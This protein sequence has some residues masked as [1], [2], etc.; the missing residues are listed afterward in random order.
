MINLTVDAHDLTKVEGTP[1]QLIVTM[2][3]QEMG[4]Q[5]LPIQFTIHGVTYTR[6]SNYQGE[7]R[8]NINLGVG[9]YPC[10]ISFDGDSEY[11]SFTRQVTVTVTGK[12]G[13]MIVCNDFVKTYGTPEPLKALLYYNTPVPGKTLIFTINGVSYERVT[14]SEGYA[15]L[16]INL[17]PG[18]YPCTVHFAGDDYYSAVTI[19]L[20]VTVRSDTR[21]EGTNI[22]KKA[23]QTVVYQCAVYDAFNNRVDCDVSL[24]V[25]GVTYIRHTDNSGLA[26]LNIRLSEGDYTLT[27]HYNGDE[28]HNGSSIVNTVHVDPDIQSITTVKQGMV[29]VPGPNRGFMESHIYLSKSTVET[30]ANYSII[31]NDFS[32]S[33]EAK[34]D[35]Y[36]TN[37]EITETDPRVKTAKFTTPRYIDLTTGRYYATITCPYH[38]NF[39]GQIIDIDYDKKTGLYTYQCQDGRRAYLTKRRTSS[40]Y[41][42]SAT[43]YD[44]LESLL[45]VPSFYNR[46]GIPAPLPKD[47]RENAKLLLT[48]LRPLEAYNLK[49]S[50]ISIKRNAYAEPCP[51]MLSYD[52]TIDKIMNL[53]HYGS[54]PVDVYFD[55]QGICQIEPIDLDKWL[56]QGI[57]L[58]HSDLESYKY[59][60]NI[61]NVITGV[62]VKAKNADEFSDANYRYDEWNDLRFYFGTNF[63]M[64]DPVTT[65]VQTGGDS[66]NN[67]NSTSANSSASGIMSGS[68]TFA[69][70]SDNITGYS[71]DMARIN[72]VISALQAKGHKAYSLGVGSNANQSHG[73]KSNSK[74]VINIFIVG[75]VCAGTIK[76]FVDGM[77]RGYYH[78]DHAIF[79]FA[80]C[81]TDNWIS[82]NALANKK[83]IRAW[84]DNFSSGIDTSIT[85]KQFFEKHPD[86][87]HYVAGQPNESWDS[88]VE[89]L[90]NGNLNCNGGN[91]NTSATTNNNTASDASNNTTTVVDETAT[92][93]KALEAMSNS[94]RDLLSFEIKLPLNHPIFKQ[95]HTNQMLWTELPGDFQ[96]E[97]LEKIFNIFGEATYK[98]NRGVKY[99]ENRWYVEKMN[100]K[101]DSNGLFATLTLNPFPSSYS[102]YSNA[103]KQYEEAYNQAFKATTTE[104]NTN[105][106][107]TNTS[108]TLVK[109][110]GNT[111]LDE[112]IK[113]WVN[114]K[115][116]G[117]DK[118]IAIHNG[119][120]DYGVKYQK[121]YDFLKSGGSITKAFQNAHAGLNCGDTSVLTVG[122][123]Q[124]VGLDAYV[125]FRCDHA[126]FFTVIVIGGTK[127]YSDLVWSEGAYSRRPWN[128]T[129]Q[130]NKCHSKYTAVNIH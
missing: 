28:T 66:T 116:T 130:N 99:R 90:V 119:L 113:G 114:G 120:K 60:F 121:Y 129:W 49:F 65:T 98:V 15:K 108:S 64:I 77:T 79:M 38:E 13:T 83:Q 40:T 2:H 5:N 101:C 124:A 107:T 3:D 7:A 16:N 75:G 123:M 27:A 87:I 106:T 34:G 94:I 111:Q 18:V 24:T 21:M 33:S 127:Y 10:T 22:V 122:C 71:S 125:G 56:S 63:G 59:G 36:F 102:T 57:K 14:D 82:C 105:T 70:G 110:T 41:D 12:Q 128:E 43:I 25:N 29:S 58:V 85:P 86:K 46:G 53:A 51:Q 72:K 92:Y 26:K 44:E 8:L 39:G 4:V 89:K 112:L 17:R 20:N 52:S 47:L 95:L 1:D 69:V 55:Q 109:S 96:L 73:S 11:N 9:V 37:Y 68:K 115:S 54:T 32:T 45:S 23:T 100:I 67:T 78:Y 126:H 117:L 118:A 31:P 103:V 48:G 88:L 97:N 81:T 6:L 74:G 84:D 62:S 50:P 93:Q 104:E 19:R 35:I 61:T 42:T 76:D 91:S 30:K 80:N